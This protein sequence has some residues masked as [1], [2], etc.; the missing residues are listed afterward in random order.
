MR[1]WR[2]TFGYRIGSACRA[3]VVLLLFALAG[4]ISGVSFAADTAPIRVASKNFNESYLLGEV[5]AQVLE[6]AGFKVER[7]FGLGGTLICFEAL[8]NDEIDLYV[9]Y[10][11]T[12]SQVILAAP[13]LT[14]LAEIDAA[15]AD[16]G[17]SL[18][19]AFGFNNTYAM[20]VRR[21]KA[22]QL[23]LRTI[24]DIGAHSEL[25]VVVSHEFLA[26]EDGW[27]GLVAT[28]AQIGRASCRE[29]V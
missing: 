15:I 21:T 16:R 14:T 9:E 12:L 27:P 23:D 3:M 20:A 29:R 2:L 26:R 10:T 22:E 5:V 18:L 7:R 1:A 25:N 28:Y 6:E 13:E 17:L 4:G 24:G 11:G 19:A 8:V